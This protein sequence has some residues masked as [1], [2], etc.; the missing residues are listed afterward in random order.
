MDLPY[1]I[2]TGDPRYELEEP[3]ERL[4]T[5]LNNKNVNIESLDIRG[6]SQ[7]IRFAGFESKQLQTITNFVNEDPEYLIK[8][9]RVRD[10]NDKFDKTLNTSNPN[11]IFKD[12]VV[13]RNNINTIR[14]GNA[15]YAKWRDLLVVPPPV[16][17][18]QKI[19]ELLQ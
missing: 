19:F 18:Q 15:S 12:D 3:L 8:S 14:G 6:N 9:N 4:Q 16:D 7:D 17:T 2:N 13:S 1:D 5:M 11:Y 10:L